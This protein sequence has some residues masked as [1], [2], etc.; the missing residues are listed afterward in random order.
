MRKVLENSRFQFISLFEELEALK[1]YR[2]LEKARFVKKFEYEMILPEN[3]S[4]ND[5]LIPTMILQPFAENSIWHG[6]S[7]LDK[8][9]N[10][11]IEILLK[12]PA[13]L[14]IIIEDNRIGREKAREIMTKNGKERKTYGTKLLEERFR[15][16]N[17]LNKTKI[18]FEYIDLYDEH[19]HPAGTRVLLHLHQIVK[20][21]SRID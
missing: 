20:N 3:V 13:E 12:Q 11:R 9:G 2:E 4:L 17:Q 8:E 21:E 19:S 10:I 5:Y 6:F 16:Y 18:G 1:T 14:L 7:T 15:L